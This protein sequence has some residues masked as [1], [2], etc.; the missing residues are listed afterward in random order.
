MGIDSKKL[1]MKTTEKYGNSNS[2]TIPV[3]IA[4]TSNERMLGNKGVFC[5]SGFG[6]G[7]TW[8]SIVMELGNM[9]FCEMIV[10]DL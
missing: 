3:T 2:S 5:L 10:S 6:S 1:P 7:E 8:A 9:S 4:D